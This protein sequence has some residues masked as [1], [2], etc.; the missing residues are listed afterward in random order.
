VELVPILRTLWRRRLL[1]ALGAA[2]ALALALALAGKAAPDRGVASVDVLV[3]TPVSQLSHAAPPGA[4]GLIARAI[5]FGNLL[6][7]DRA[8]ARIARDARVPP[9]ELAVIM[10]SAA[11]PIL[12]SALAVH[13]A[14]AAAARPEKYVVMVHVD[15]TVPLVRVDAL[16]P[17]PRG[18]VRLADAVTN[19]METAAAPDFRRVVVNPVGRPQA[20]VIPGSSGRVKALGAAIVVFALWCGCVVFASVLWRRAYAPTNTRSGVSALDD[21]VWTGVGASRSLPAPTT[22]ATKPARY[23]NM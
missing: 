11:T 9:N 17:E 7:T 18:A 20:R 4:D 14:E 8:Q 5:L 1:V 3:D 22:T 19:A 15:S 10:R 12:P 23:R 13:A 2:V 6:A 16:A 21:S